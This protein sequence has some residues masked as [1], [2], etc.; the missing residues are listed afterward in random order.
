MV[1]SPAPPTSRASI[2]LTIRSDI[3]LAHLSLRFAP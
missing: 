1:C 3:A 2:A